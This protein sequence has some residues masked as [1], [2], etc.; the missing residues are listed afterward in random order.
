MAKQNGSR[1]IGHN[2]D[3]SQSMK[4]YNLEMRWERNKKRRIATDA[5]RQL[6]IFDRHQRM[7]IKGYSMRRIMRSTA[8]A[9]AN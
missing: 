7:G 6:A 5:R 9:S 8:H 2:R 3:R 4:R 1:K